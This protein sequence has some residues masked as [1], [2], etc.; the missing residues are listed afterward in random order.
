MNEQRLSCQGLPQKLRLCTDTL[1]ALLL[2]ISGE[3]E[4]VLRPLG[5]HG[6]SASNRFCSRWSRA[7]RRW[8]DSIF[9]NR[10]SI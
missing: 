4:A 3:V 2:G 7:V 1:D 6:V 10:V 8:G 9:S 5:R